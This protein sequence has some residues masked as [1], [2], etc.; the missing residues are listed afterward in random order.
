MTIAHRLAL[1][2]CACAALACAQSAQ[3]SASGSAELTNIRFTLTD[4]D[5]NDGIAPSYTLITNQ[6]STTI[7]GVGSFIFTPAPDTDLGLDQ[8]DT[9]Q[10]H[11]GGVGSTLQSTASQDG[12]EVISQTLNGTYLINTNLGSGLTGNQFY[13]GGAGI[14]SGSIYDEVIV[15]LGLP[16]SGSVA[17]LLSANTQ[18][19]VSADVS[20]HLQGVID[21][22]NCVSEYH[23]IGASLSAHGGSDPYFSYFDA[24]AS[25]H[26]TFDQMGD[27]TLHEIYNESYNGT[28]S[29]D[30]FNES[31]GTSQDP[32]EVRVLF[33][34]TTI[35]TWQAGAIPEPG[36]YALV[37]IGLGAA[38]W[39]ARRRK[40]A[41]A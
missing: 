12:A 18:L 32:K 28:L 33:G 31:D 40:P 8:L 23:F 24:S 16:A 14:G 22:F 38:A 3:A 39:Q 34:V 20:L 4:L 6:G 7:T 26:L 30:Y 5:P 27:D 10:M 36:T 25:Q 35:G 41:S 15:P 13:M 17:G 2:A 29:L 21:C 1:T 9:A 19:T 11:F 37:G